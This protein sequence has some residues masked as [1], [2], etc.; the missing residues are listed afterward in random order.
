VGKKP[1]KI[2]AIG[3]G[4]ESFGRGILADVLGARELNDFDCT[5]ALVDINPVALERMFRLAGLLRSH[6]ASGVKLERT[7][8]RGQAL[9]GADYV[10]ISVAIQRYPLWEQD[11]RVPLAYGF[12]HVLGE[13]GGP[14][15]LFHSLRSFELVLPICRD[16]E[17]LCPDALVLNYTNPESR[18]VKAIHAL[19]NVRA[20]GLCHGIPGARAAVSRILNRPEEELDMVAGGLNHFFWF[21]RIAD[22]Q[23]G[24]D[25]YPVLKQRV[26]EDPDCPAAPPLVRKMMDIFGCYTYPSDD[27]IGE[28]LSFA[29]EFTGVLWPYGQESRRVPRPG[30]EPKVEDRL[31]PY[32]RGAKPLDEHITDKSGEMAIPILLDIELNRRMW[33]P[34]VN[35][36]NGGG[37]VANLPSD[38]VVEVPAWVD[39]DGV[40]PDRI[41]PLPEALAAFCRTQASI[42]QLLVEAY[43]KHSRNLLLQALLLDPVVDSVWK[44]EQMLD[45]MLELQKEFLPEFSQA[46]A[47]PSPPLTPVDH[48]P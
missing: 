8:D 29:Y 18:V 6:Y 3:V 39:G 22:R 31:E 7:T 33:R 46:G 19:T 2:V 13:N 12:R 38:A 35:V 10:V 44:A 16:I 42:Q 9:P 4:S 5:L 17:R 40:H 14:G 23:T 20:V 27:H 11:F 25:L 36:P 37:Y 41:G 30:T 1:L 47:S 15:A 48:H 26:V 24:E 43:R 34:A 21:T 32:L 45:E 28:Y